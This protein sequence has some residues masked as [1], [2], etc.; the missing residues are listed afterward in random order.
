MKK[1][2]DFEFISKIF[3]SALDLGKFKLKPNS[4]FEEVPDWDSLGHMRIIQEL[5]KGNAIS[6]DM[7]TYRQALRDLPAGKDTVDK[8]ENATWPTKP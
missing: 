2:I 1:K 4:K 5:E 6:S 8:C 7:K 3:H